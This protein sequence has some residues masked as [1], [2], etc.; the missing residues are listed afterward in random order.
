MYKSSPKDPQT[1]ESPWTI[2]KLLGW[3]TSYFESKNIEGA[4]A[5]AE[6][7]LADTLNLNRIDL[8]LRHDQ[9]LTPGELARFKSLIKRRVKR[10]PVAYITGRKEFWSMDLAVT[11]DVLIPRPE[12]ECLV[13]RAL[14]AI[15]D[16]NS[17][18]PWKILELGTGSGAIILALA[19]EKPGHLYF[20]SDLSQS[21]LKIAK[22]NAQNHGLSDR[23]S[24]FAGN[25]F[26]PLKANVRKFHLIVSNP[27]YIQT[28]IIETLEPEVS[29][30]EPRRALDGGQS[31]M[32]SLESIIVRAPAFLHP[33]SLLILEIG[34]DQR[35]RTEYTVQKSGQ[36]E[37]VEFITDYGGHDRVA[38]LKTRL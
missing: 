14:T 6:I 19:S 35:D 36:Y 2:L 22:A 34:Y 18:Q 38:V 30:H 17:G 16:K 13:E 28:R 11:P 21:A 20:A 23:I 15:P 29:R 10:E 33:E 4:R 25:W 37:S 7:L 1:R 5:S 8:Y 31:G 9:P 3:T 26:D 32:A 24:F 27:P 12:T